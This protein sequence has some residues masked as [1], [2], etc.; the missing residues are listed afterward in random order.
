MT[1]KKFSFF[2]LTNLPIAWIAGVRLKHLDRSGSTTSIKLHKMS[3]NPFKS[4]FWAVQGMAAELSTGV[5]LFDEMEK[6]GRRFSVL[7]THQEAFFTKKAVGKCTFTCDE[8]EKLREAMQRAYDSDVPQSIRVS[9]IGIDEGGNQISEFFF[10]W[11]IK[12]K[13]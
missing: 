7:V 5:Q 1:S 4:I 6:S 11:S 8:G 3:Q 13:K 9:S 2:L 12:A 10:T